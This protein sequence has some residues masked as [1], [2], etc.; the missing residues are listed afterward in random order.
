MIEW[1]NLFL[2]P[3]NLY[4]APG[5]K[6]MQDTLSPAYKFTVTEQNNVQTITLTQVST[7]RTKQFTLTGKSVVGLSIHMASMS[8]D[9]CKPYFK[10]S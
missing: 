5:R 3:I 9:T 7:G 8:D 4:N 6:P 10:G 1:P 2:P